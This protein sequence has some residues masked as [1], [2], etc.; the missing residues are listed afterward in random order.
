M[1]IEL[2]K[3]YNEDCFD[4]MSRMD[5]GSIDIVLTS[6]P[7]NMTKRKGGYADTGRYDVYQDWLTEDEY[8]EKS[9]SL[10]NEFN[11]IVKHNGLVIYN[12]SYS[13]E[14]PSLPY[15]LVADIVADTEWAVVDT[16]IW[17]KKSGLPFP[18]NE[19]RLSRIWEFVWVFA[20]KS[21][22]NTFKCN[23]KLKSISEKTGQKYYEVYYNIIEAK[24]NDTATSK[25]N[26]ATYSTDLC[27]QLLNIYAKDGYTIYDP[28]MGT[29]TTGNACKNGNL[30]LNYIG[31]E[32][33]AQQCEYAENR[34]GNSTILRNYK[35]LDCKV[36]SI[37]STSI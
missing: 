33:S 2:N 34:I 25:L 11:R 18:A 10:F 32:I 4:T 6:P 27:L 37:S 17:R 8:V 26:Q 9:V 5:D 35:H 3:I 23:K 1:A 28:F 21:E 16:I 29:G 22:V 36:P 31:S 12:F 19:R 15:R 7:Y 20:R 24:N 30:K 14:N 13:I